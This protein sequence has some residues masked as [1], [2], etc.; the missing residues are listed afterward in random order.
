MKKLEHKISVWLTASPFLCSPQ[1]TSLVSSYFKQKKGE[2][3][4][5]FQ[6]LEKEEVELQAGKVL[7]PTIFLFKFTNS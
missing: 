1:T 7:K 6:F 2:I 5:F 3:E 4:F